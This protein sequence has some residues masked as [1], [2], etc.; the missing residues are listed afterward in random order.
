MKGIF[1]GPAAK[2]W[3]GFR[4]DAPFNVPYFYPAGLRLPSTSR[5]SVPQP[6]DFLCVLRGS[7]KNAKVWNLSQM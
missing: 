5:C 3:L 4:C 2:P 7:A 1:M 6:N